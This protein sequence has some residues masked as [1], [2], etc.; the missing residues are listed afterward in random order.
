MFSKQILP[1]ATM[2]PKRI[3]VD[4]SYLW[5]LCQSLGYYFTHNQISCLMLQMER[6]VCK[7]SALLSRLC[8]NWLFSL[9]DVVCSG[10]V[11]TNVLLMIIMG[12]KWYLWTTTT[13][14]ITA[15]K[16]IKHSSVMVLGVALLFDMFILKQ[17]VRFFFSLEY[18]NIELPL[19]NSDGV[20]CIHTCI[21]AHLVPSDRQTYCCILFSKG[22]FAVAVNINYS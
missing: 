12:T 7:R 9:C 5:S 14:T 10:K 17:K 19:R 21:L 22:V 6:L 1:T 2:D 11:D 15:S 4:P 8:L 20:L 16:R 13:T 3:C 18:K